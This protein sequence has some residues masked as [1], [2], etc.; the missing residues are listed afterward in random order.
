MPSPLV[1][2]QLAVKDPASTRAFL[3]ELF[4]WQ[5]AEPDERG[6]IPVNPDGPG[7]FDVGG[8]L[9]P[10]REGRQQVTLFFRVSDLW[11]TVA[12]SEELGGRTLMPIR[13]PNPEGAH[14]AIVQT[15]DGELN[16][17]IVQA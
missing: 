10:L 7:D 14:I 15:P 17:G 9:M 12:R 6:A 5:P 2:F 16:V 3:D 13:Q 1:F 8:S 4:D 11:A